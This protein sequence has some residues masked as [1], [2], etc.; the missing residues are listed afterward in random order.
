M[1]H[2][3]FL[4]ALTSISSVLYWHVH[5]CGDPNS[6]TVVFDRCSSGD[7]C[8]YSDWQVVPQRRV[9]L[10]W[11]TGVPWSTD[12]SQETSAPSIQWLTG[13]QVFLQGHF[14]LLVTGWCFPSAT[15]APSVTD[16]VPLVAIQFGPTLT[17]VRALQ[18]IQLWHR[19]MLTFH[20]HATAYQPS[21]SQKI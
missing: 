8:F 19:R 17:S 2:V 7:T 3:S 16:S 14:F 4:P 12:G 21:T 18:Y 11:L 20:T 1:A 13:V 6:C 5:S 15:S 9:H 10:M